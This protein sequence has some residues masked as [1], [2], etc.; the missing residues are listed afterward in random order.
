MERERSAESLATTARAHGLR[1]LSA[2]QLTALTLSLR[3]QGTLCQLRHLFQDTPSGTQL[4]S[5]LLVSPSS[6]QCLENV[7]TDL[8]QCPS[9]HNTLQPPRP[10][11]ENKLTLYFASA[12]PSPLDAK[13]APILPGQPPVSVFLWRPFNPLPS[14]TMS[15]LVS[16]PSAAQ[17]WTLR[18]GL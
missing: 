5:L 15:H 9:F 6:Q 14:P 7:T 12:S 13:R 4:L 11:K 16:P 8:S 18:P 1:P 2:L 17:F 3:P 10:E